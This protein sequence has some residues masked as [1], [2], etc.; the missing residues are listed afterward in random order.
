MHCVLAT[1]EIAS[2]VSK[3]QL[4]LLKLP[5]NTVAKQFLRSTNF[6]SVHQTGML[7]YRNTFLRVKLPCGVLCAENRALP[8]LQYL[9]IDSLGANPFRVVCHTGLFYVL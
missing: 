6:A 8:T 7:G 1:K 5:Q 4:Q 2:F 9:G 3:V